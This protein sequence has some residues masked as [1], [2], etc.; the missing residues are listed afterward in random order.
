[1]KTHKIVKIKWID[2]AGYRGWR[3][4]DKVKECEP[5]TCYSCG[6]LVK[7]KKGSIGVTHSIAPLENDASDFQVIPK[8]AIKEIEVLSTFR[9]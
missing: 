9:A 7:T 3:D 4:M 5:S 2:S 6:I 1:M 8:R